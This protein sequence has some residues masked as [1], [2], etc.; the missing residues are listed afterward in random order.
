MKLLRTFIDRHL[1]P[2]FDPK[3]GKLKVLFPVY[4]MVD[5]IL[6]T[7]G[8]VTKRAP[9]VRDGLDLKRVMITVVFALIPCIL[10]A[11][12]NTGYQANLALGEMGEL[13]EK[14]WQLG[15]IEFL[16][17]GT[18]ADVVLD[19][20]V[21]GL[22]YFLPVYLVVMLTGG[23]WEVLFA[24][25][26]KHDVTEAFLVTGTLIALILPPNI[27][28]WQVFLGTSFGVVIGKEIF[29]GVGFN[30][31]NPALTA[32]VFLFFAYPAEISGDQV[33][34]ALDGY[35]KA[36]PLALGAEGG[37]EKILAAG[38]TWKESFLG[39][40][41]G[42]MG[43]TSTLL[44]LLGAC[45]LMMTGIGSWRIMLFVFLGMVSSSYLFN[46][47]NQTGLIINPMFT[48]PPWWHLVLGGFGFGMVFMA[49]DPV[50]AA[51]T[52]KGKNLYGFLIGILSMVIRVI[53]PAFPEGIML[54]ILLVNVFSPV[55]DHFFIESNIK[56]RMSRYG[57]GKLS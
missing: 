12:Y 13:S 57:K 55:I 36:T 56:K 40:I 22:L 39:L 45:Y 10:M 35:T 25:I 8:S 42:S 32:R 51:M 34:V 29:G 54:A 19:C 46:V 18:S 4:E 44:C 11:I 50:S 26:R 2:L 1:E 37:L 43:E 3:K 53:N 48:L 17:F 16:G 9:H 15:L 49:T 21:H 38:F 33:W 41:P 23:F 6:F 47:L 27:P 20:F 31:L 24:V 14:G 30:F 52:E 28:L 7:P 5:T